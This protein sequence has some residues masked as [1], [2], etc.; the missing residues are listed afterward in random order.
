MPNHEV[1]SQL[2][3]GVDTCDLVAG[4]HRSVASRAASLAKRLGIIE[5]IFMTGGVAQNF[6]VVR[7]LEKELGLKVRTDPRAQLAGAIGAALL[8][9]EQKREEK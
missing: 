5:P 8:A 4:I 6:G 9:W 7:A 1:I 2:A 3:Q